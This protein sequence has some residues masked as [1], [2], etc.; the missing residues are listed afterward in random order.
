MDRAD[1]RMV[2]KL[3]TI[4]EAHPMVCQTHDIHLSYPSSKERYFSAH[5]V[6]DETLTLGEVESVIETLR[7]DLSHAGATHILLQPETAKYDGGN[8]QCNGHIEH[9]H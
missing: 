6:L 7:H 8:E 2:A 5:I 1:P 3:T 4:L 9:H